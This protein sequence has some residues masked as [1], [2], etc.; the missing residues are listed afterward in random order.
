VNETLL[1]SIVTQPSSENYVYAYNFSTLAQARNL[2]A[3]STCQTYV[4]TITATTTPSSTTTTTVDRGG[5]RTI[6][7][8]TTRGFFN[9]KLLRVFVCTQMSLFQ[10]LSTWSY[11]LHWWRWSLTWRSRFAVKFHF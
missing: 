6:P 9:G 3:G 5:N 10:F 2:L 4:L 8:Y 11:M 1:R 7:S